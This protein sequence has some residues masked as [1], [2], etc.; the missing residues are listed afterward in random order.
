MTIADDQHPPPHAGATPD[1][2]DYVARGP[3]ARAAWTAV[4]ALAVVVGSIGIV[5]PGLP[6]TIFFII[7]AWAFSRS[8]PRLEAWV[9]GLKGVGPAV[10][11]YRA[12]DG[13]PRTAKIAAITMMVLASVISCLLLDA[14]W[15]QALV[16]G[17]AAVGVVVVLRT[18]TSPAQPKPTA[19]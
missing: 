3:I 10:A 11:A 9:L 2:H 19:R 8:S 5:V 7:A 1:A 14:W 6:T 15:T 16:I 17:L 18:P 4:G 12:G 13:M